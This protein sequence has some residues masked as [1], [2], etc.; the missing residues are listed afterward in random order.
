M[1]AGVLGTRKGTASMQGKGAGPVNRVEL[2]S[3]VLCAALRQSFFGKD[4]IGSFT[5]IR[6]LSH[7]FPDLLP[8][9]EEKDS[10]SETNKAD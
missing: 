10:I 6:E 1:I 5:S 3:Q 4:K 8:P 9:P 7:L 2:E